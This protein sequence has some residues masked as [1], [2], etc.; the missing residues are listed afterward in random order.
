MQGPYLGLR[1]IEGGLQATCENTMVGCQ[2]L[3]LSTQ[4]QAQLAAAAAMAAA[5]AAAAAAAAPAVWRSGSAGDDHKPAANFSSGPKLNAY[6]CVCVCVM[7][8]YM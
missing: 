1:V 8:V 2:S 4:P 7:S 6:A 5:L 3:F